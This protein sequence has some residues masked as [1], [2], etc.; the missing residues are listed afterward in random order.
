MKQTLF[1]IV[2]MTICGHYTNAQNLWWDSNHPALPNLPTDNVARNGYVGLGSKMTNISAD[3]PKVG[4]FEI[5][6][7]NT[8]ASSYPWSAFIYNEAETS[9]Q[10]LRLKG[11]NSAMDD[12][13]LQIEA[14]EIPGG[15]FGAYHENNFVFRAFS[16]KKV[17]IGD[18]SF[19]SDDYSLFVENGII[20]ES[21]RV[22]VP[23]SLE[24]P[25][26][27]FEPEYRLR[28]LNDV[29][30]FIA[31]NGHLPNIPSAS[32]VCEKGI[33]LVDM[34]AKLLEKIE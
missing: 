27:V 18:V 28:D 24:W 12:P 29:K 14:R 20:T 2:L 5:N 10:L 6:S 17:V 22:A 13:L 7:D 9:P 19:V 21:V 30:Q 32:E 3:W 34:D 11:G 25:D 8:Q 15:P 23:G 1:I 31:S 4:W 33:D 16:N 26:Y